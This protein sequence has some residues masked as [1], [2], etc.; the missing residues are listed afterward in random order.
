[1]KDDSKGSGAASS[2]L[3]HPDSEELR[4]LLKGAEAREA[5]R[6][7]WESQ[8]EPRPMSD[9]VE[10]SRSIFGKTNSNT[11]RRLREVYSVFEVRRYKQPG[12]GAWVYEL[13]RQAAAAKDTAR[14]SP[15]LQARVFAV[16]GRF[17]AMCG[18]SPADG[19]KLQIDHIVPRE[20]GGLTELDNLEPLCVPHNHG[21]K[22]FFATF[23]E[24]GPLI[25]R[26]MP[27]ADPWL[28]IGKLLKGFYAM[29]KPCPVE[30]IYLVARETHKGDPLKRLRE[31][32]FVLGW[33]IG[34]S[35]TKDSGGVTH[36]TYRLAGAPPPWPAAGPAAEVLRYERERKA[37]KRAGTAA[38]L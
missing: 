28:R 5:Y 24:V 8:A 15:A 19:V 21:K 25:R 14:I 6:W 1:M 22:A 2:G 38:A 23:D 32:R 29:E 10:R 12:T 16:K 13:V 18:L 26:A 17:C 33:P 30:L 11:G 27:E 20:W 36:V 37:R 9:W 3:P 4:A 7:L 31:L 34:S 35:R